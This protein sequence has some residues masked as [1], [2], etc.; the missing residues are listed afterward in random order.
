MYTYIQGLRGTPTHHL[1]VV[2]FKRHRDP[3][4]GFCARCG[5]RAPCAANRHAALVIA[6]AGEDP[7]RCLVAP[8]RPSGASAPARRAQERQIRDAPVIEA[9]HSGYRVGGRGRAPADSAGKDY[10][11]DDG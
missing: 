2:V 4:T 5:N 7:R 11:R 9:A 8:Q 1:S 10:Q 6:A 3:G